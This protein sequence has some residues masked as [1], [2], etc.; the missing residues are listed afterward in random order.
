[1]LCDADA[2][3]WHDELRKELV[4]HVRKEIGPFASPD[5]IQF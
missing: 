1:L 5:R 3:K 4:A 2:A